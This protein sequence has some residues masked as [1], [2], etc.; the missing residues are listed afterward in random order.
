MSEFYLDPVLHTGRPAEKRDPVED[1]CYDLLDRL[2]IPYWRAD[3]DPAAAVEACVA[4][5][6]VVGVP[7]CKNLFLCTRNK[8]QYFLVM[9]PGDKPFRTADFSRILGT[10]RLS[11]GSPEDM[12]A[13]IG[14]VPGSVSILG[15]Q[16]D[17]ALRVRLCID[18]EI[19]LQKYMRCHPCRNTSTLRIAT[20]DVLDRL[21]PYLRHKPTIIELPRHAAAPPD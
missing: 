11:F 6:G 13:M 19:T 9:L 17:K 21:L 4:V 14:V 2:E 7:A 5:A 16:Y 1:G 18:R 10:S 3:H 15:L 12:L 8:S 20:T